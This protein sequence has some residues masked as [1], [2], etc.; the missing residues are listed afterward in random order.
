MIAG[1]ARCVEYGAVAAVLACVAHAQ[2]PAGCAVVGTVASGRAALPGVALS[3]TRTDASVSDPVDVTSTAV[4]GTFL[5]KAA[6]AGSYV[7]KAELIGFAPIR[8]Q[9]TIDTTQCPLRVD[10]TM[11]LAS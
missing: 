7:L 2:S 9:L 11:E 5:L 6:D 4:D 1:I 3:L 8:R 10:L